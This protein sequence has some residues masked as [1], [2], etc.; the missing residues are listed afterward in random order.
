MKTAAPDHLRP[1]LRLERRPLTHPDSARLVEQVQAEYVALYGGPDESPIDP[2]EF[3]GGTGAFYV[4]YLGD[5]PVATGAWRRVAPPEGVGPG[6]CAEIK[7]MYVAAGHRGRGLARQVLRQLEEAAAA[8]G[9]R[10][11]VLETGLRQPEAIA[12]YESSGYR[13]IPGY[14][15]YCGSDLSRC[16]AKDLASASPVDTPS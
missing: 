12:L 15:Y 1:A 11:L 6:P 8:A 16:F 14:G 2:G 5:L 3:E 13:R 4:G 7:R 10:A 9:M